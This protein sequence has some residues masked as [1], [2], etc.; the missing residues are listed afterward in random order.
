MSVR[1]SSNQDT[2]RTSRHAYAR[3]AALVVALA[4]AS[5]DDGA[6]FDA[7][8]PTWVSA[9]E[10]LTPAFTDPPLT[11]LDPRVRFAS[12]IHYGSDD[13]QVFDVLL[14]AS[15]APT[16]AVLYFHGGGFVVGS[17]TDVYAGSADDVRQLLDAGVAWIGATLLLSSSGRRARNLRKAPLPR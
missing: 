3:L 17:R 4:T 11:G 1:K 5:C 2:W 8:D 15:D 16:A 9:D 14:P 7:P 12:S 6:T 13:Q 10:P